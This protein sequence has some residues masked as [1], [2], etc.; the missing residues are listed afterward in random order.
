MSKSRKEIC[1]FLLYTPITFCLCSLLRVAINAP[2]NPP[3]TLEAQNS[4]F[5]PPPV[6]TYSFEASLNSYLSC[7]PLF[8]FTTTASRAGISREL[9]IIALLN[10]PEI[11]RGRIT[12]VVSTIV[13]DLNE[14]NLLMR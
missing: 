2:Q 5:T 9:L 10:G 7:F 8:F 4:F 13:R 11:K 3:N 14:N 1:F 12:K 6:Y